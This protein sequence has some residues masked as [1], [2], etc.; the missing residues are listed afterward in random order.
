MKKRVETTKENATGRNIEF[1][2]IKT[3][4]KMTR[5]EFVKRI[6]KNTSNYADDYY[7]RKQ[8]GLKTPVARPDEKTKNNLD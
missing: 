4:E 7:V 8:N 5:A 1:K 6:E 3:N 2:D